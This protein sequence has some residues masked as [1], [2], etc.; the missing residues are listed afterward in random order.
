M[1]RSLWSVTS[2]AVAALVLACGGAEEPADEAAAPET[3]E[4]AEAQ[5]AETAVDPATIRQGDKEL[6][7]HGMDQA[8]L[9]AMGEELWND[10]A[11]G[12][13]GQT[14]ASCHVDKYAMMKETFAEPYPHH[15]KMAEDQAGMSEVTAAEMVQL[16]MVIPMQSDPLA[17]D[18][19]ELAALTAYVE[20]IRPGFDPSMAGGGMNPCNPCAANPCNPCA[21]NPCNPC[22]ANPCNPCAGA[23]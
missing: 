18:S 14:C 8:E 2:V 16:C 10:P 15:V 4:T 11:L 22:A 7:P 12:S 17:Y 23:D 9:V 21:A 20:D 19:Q 5:P 6:D 3:E 1:K 13:S